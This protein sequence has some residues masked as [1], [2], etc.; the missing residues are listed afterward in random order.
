MEG[1]CNCRTAYKA[2]GSISEIKRS[3]IFS[4]DYFSHTQKN[5]DL[6]GQNKSEHVLMRC[7]SCEFSWLA[8]KNRSSFV[9]SRL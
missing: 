4:V 3:A 9:S 1:Y 6:F 2:R 7:R 5:D 8:R